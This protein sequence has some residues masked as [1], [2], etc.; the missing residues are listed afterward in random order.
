MN[1][2]QSYFLTD[3]PRFTPGRKVLFTFVLTFACIGV[4][5]WGLQLRNSVYAPYALS[6]ATPTNLKQQLVD[7]NMEY[8]KE[9]DT[10]GNGISD[11][12]KIYVYGTSRFLYDTYGY[13]MADGEVLKR[14]LALCPGAGKNC[15]GVFSAEGGVVLAGTSSPAL[16]PGSPVAV[17]SPTSLGNPTSPEAL[18]SLLND[19][20]KIRQL[21]KQNANIS[22]ADLQKI[23]DADLI[24]T[25][26]TVFASSTLSA[27][28][29]P[30]SAT[31]SGR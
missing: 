17:G 19:P 22:D 13:G 10:S 20:A 29:R 14:G 18:T 5:L 2:E 1:D 12:D 6:S 16:N 24:K 7:N 26:Q 9:I 15:G 27:T 4:I 11:Y 31:S 3:P 25:V 28:V 8:L 23:S 30:V 21:L